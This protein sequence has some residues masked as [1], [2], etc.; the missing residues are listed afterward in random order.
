[1]GHNGHIAWNLV[2]ELE[3]EFLKTMIFYSL[4]TSTWHCYF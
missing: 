4:N 3:I 2:K 1:M